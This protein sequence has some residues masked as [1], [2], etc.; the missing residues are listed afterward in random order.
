MFS[1]PITSRLT[2]LL[3]VATAILAAYMLVIEPIIGGYSE[4][5]SEIETARDQLARLERAA[6][7]R[8]ALA[9]HIENFEKQRDSESYFLAGSTDALAAAGL[10]D[11]VQALII[12]HG[13][14]LQSIQT[15]SGVEEQ[16][17]IRIT[18]RV[19]MTATTE[20]L[21]DVLCALESGSPIL[22]IDDVDVQSREGVKPSDAA[23]SDME[24]L[25]VA[26]DVSGY[27]PRD[28]QR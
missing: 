7:M 5:G 27:L 21:F 4:T 12:E 3:L 11:R 23:A 20:T 14:T 17:L 18:L 6:A 1:T 8:P 26:V 2:A 22:F 19:Q 15:I 16:Q 25:T 9:K 28:A 24:R 13:G 10:Q